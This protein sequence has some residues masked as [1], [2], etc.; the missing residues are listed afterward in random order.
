MV[1]HVDKEML[2][3]LV[4]WSQNISLEEKLDFK[5]GFGQKIK[6]ESALSLDRISEKMLIRNNREK[7]CLKLY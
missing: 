3:I 5:V 1:G 2:D 4:W 7:F 6:P